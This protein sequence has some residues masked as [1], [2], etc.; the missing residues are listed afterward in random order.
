MSLRFVV[1]IVFIIICSLGCKLSHAW[2]TPTARRA[3]TAPFAPLYSSSTS[4]EETTATV[5]SSDSLDISAPNNALDDDD[6]YE[7]I[8]YEVLTE[9][10]FLNSEWLVGT[11][12]D[13]RPDKID[14]TWARLIVDRDGK[15]VVVWGDGAEGS[16]NLDVASQFLSV[17]KENKFTGKDIWAC[18]VTD[19]YYLQGTV[20]GWR[21]WAAASVIGQWQARRLGV[22]PEEAGVA[23]WFEEDEEEANAADEQ[24]QLPSDSSA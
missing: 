16:W 24:N 18:S 21:F 6:E 2:V 17:S 1:S 20:R 15:N 23:P 9:A 3:S 14:E 5:S 12:R 10:E 4:K 22:D 13:S 7:Y 8:E 19:Y 11:N